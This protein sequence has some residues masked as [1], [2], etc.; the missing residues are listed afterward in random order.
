MVRRSE[1]RGAAYHDLRRLLP[2]GDAE[3]LRAALGLLLLLLLLGGCGALPRPFEPEDKTGNPLLVP[4]EGQTLEVLALQG[5]V[6]DLPMGGAL[7]LAEGLAAGGIPVTIEDRT[8][9]S[10][11]LLGRAALREE[12]SLSDRLAVRW[13]VYGP[14]GSLL[15]GIDQEIELPRGRWLSGDPETLRKVGLAA[16]P[17]LAP[18]A[19]GPEAVTPV[20]QGPEL[21]SGTR[22]PIAV[23]GLDG[24]PGDGGGSLP[25]AL[26]SVLTQRGFLVT[27][28]LAVQGFAV[29]GLMSVQPLGDGRE[30]ISVAWRVL[31]GPYGELLGQ[32]EQSNVIAAGSLDGPWGET[33]AVIAVGAA[34]GIVDLLRQAGK[35]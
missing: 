7:R 17:L 8:A 11:L 19:T 1:A 24:A 28:D 12:G 34:D 10:R 9:Q 33:A 35:L 14:G 31:S 16:A 26:A 30:R 21:G 29:D 4:V 18:L 23:L 25:R 15:Q 3:H 13:E 2:A 5:D 32:V 20:P 6:P 22:P 27:E